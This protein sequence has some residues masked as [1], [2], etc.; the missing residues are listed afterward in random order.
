MKALWTQDEASYNGELVR[1]EPSWA[2]PKPTQRPHPPIVLGGAAGPKTAAHV[3]EF[4]DGWMPIG[5]RGLKTGWDEVR[6]ACDN[7]GR[8][9]STI[10]LGVFGAPPDEAKLTELALSGLSRAVITMPQGTRDEVIAA[11]ES[12]APLIEKMRH[13]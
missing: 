7:V 1:I 5:G 8:D 9:P 2:W 11:L 13:V 12:A 6:R 10:E 3:A 4:C